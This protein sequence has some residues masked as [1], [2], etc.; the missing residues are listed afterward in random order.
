MLWIVE[1]ET[2]F[3]DF[4]CEE[5]AKIHSRTRENLC[6]DLMMCLLY[7]HAGRSYKL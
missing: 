2:K 4:G 1:R 6:G 7:L 3:G 5:S